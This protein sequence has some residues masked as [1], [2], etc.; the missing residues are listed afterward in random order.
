[1]R[2]NQVPRGVVSVLAL[3]LAGWSGGCI[4]GPPP[5]NQ[6]QRVGQA[7]RMGPDRRVVAQPPGPYQ[8]QFEISVDPSAM[9]ERRVEMATLIESLR[10]FFEQYPFF[11]LG[12]L[13]EMTV[14]ATNGREVEL[15]NFATVNVW[16]DAARTEIVVPK[17]VSL[18]RE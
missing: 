10:Q 15:R 11:S 12:E 4:F 17:S 1:M 8:A 13:Q 7:G 2:T 5:P 16:F 14:R 6:N 9:S 3:A 18:K